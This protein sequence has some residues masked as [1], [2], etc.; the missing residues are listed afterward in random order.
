MP[1]VNFTKVII[2]GICSS[3]DSWE[4][5]QSCCIKE[6]LFY[7]NGIDTDLCKAETNLS[8]VNKYFS[9][10]GRLIY[11]ST[12]NIIKDLKEAIEDYSWGVKSTAS[13]KFEEP[14]INQ[15]TMQVLARLQ[16]AKESDLPIAFVGSSQGTLIT[17]NAMLAFYFLAE[18]N[19]EYLKRKVRV[20]HVGSVVPQFNEQTMRNLLNKYTAITN[21]KDPLAMVVGLKAN[22]KVA[23]LLSGP[24][25]KYHELKWYLPIS[26]YQHIIEY[27]GDEE[28]FVKKDFFVNPDITDPTCTKDDLSNSWLQAFLNISMQYEKNKVKPRKG[29][30][31]EPFLNKV[32]NT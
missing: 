7:V 17:Y 26:D 31:L 21:P 32:M 1:N 11:N 16:L 13:M 22:H 27:Y 15:V 10:S 2:G 8:I 25:G 19:M 6:N 30:W 5:P 14:I 18:E 4:R 3:L 28:P 23:A 12:E 9:V 20:C 24:T 29:I